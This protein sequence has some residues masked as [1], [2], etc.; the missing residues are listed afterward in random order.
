MKRR[1]N[2]GYKPLFALALTIGAGAAA[3]LY[4]TYAYVFR[5][6]KAQRKDDGYFRKRSNLS[7]E[8]K[9]LYSWMAELSEHEHENVEITSYDGTKLCGK[10]Y[11]VSD[12]APL[13][14]AFHGYRS[15]AERDFCG[16]AKICFDNGINLLTVDQRAHGNSGGN[17]LTF[18]IKERYDCLEWAKYASERFGNDTK[19][20]LAGVSMGAATVLMASDLDLPENV[21][22]IIADCPYSSPEEIIKKVCKDK[23]LP[24]EI[25]YPAVKTGAKLFG[26]FD[27]EEDGAKKSVQNAKV[28]VLLIHGLADGFVPH[29]MSESIFGACSADRTLLEVPEADHAR[30]YLVNKELYEKT[31]LEFIDKCR[32]KK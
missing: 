13:E 29:E 2:N 27:L 25:F 23:K 24:V 8:E 6:F 15:L 11:H 19:I 7:D 16:G 31:V 14:I 1:K 4:G 12:N 9:T 26:K 28:P 21:V 18:G 22:G 10:Y 32:K 17:T 20:I 30:S 5:V 3:F